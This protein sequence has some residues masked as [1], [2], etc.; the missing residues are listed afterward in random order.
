MNA[1]DIF[2]DVEK[3]SDAFLVYDLQKQVLANYSNPSLLV[4]ISNYAITDIH[5]IWA[6]PSLK[7]HKRLI[8]YNDF[9]SN[10]FSH[11]GLRKSGRQKYQQVTL[12]RNGP[13]FCSSQ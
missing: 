6:I 13:S 4:S 10:L 7:S 12:V 9:F 8:L 3:K 2:F 11:L 1:W 5:Y